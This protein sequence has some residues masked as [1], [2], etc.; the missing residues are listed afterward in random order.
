MSDANQGA[1]VD[2]LDT[3][4]DTFDDLLTRWIDA[5]A[6]GDA[7]ALD[8]L[9]DAD[10]RGDDPGGSVLTKQEWLGRSCASTWEGVAVRVLADSIIV[11]GIRSGGGN[12]GRFPATLVTARRDGR[13]W[14][15]NLQLGERLATPA[16]QD[17]PGGRC[18]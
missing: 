15:V 8:A 2:G 4:P 16:P 12:G 18:P 11:R 14:V 10:F 13:W 7:A 3:F 5:E 17:R 9:L 6:R 1:T